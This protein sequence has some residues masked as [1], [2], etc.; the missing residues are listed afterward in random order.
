MVQ[1]HLCSLKRGEPSAW[2]GSSSIEEA[3]VANLGF[4]EARR[5][6]WGF[7]QN[8]CHVMTYNSRCEVLRGPESKQPTRKLSLWPQYCIM[9]LSKWVLGSN[10]RTF[11]RFSHSTGN[12]SQFIAL[13]SL[14]P[15]GN[16][17]RG[18][19]SM[20]QDLPLNQYSFFLV[21]M[22]VAFHQQGTGK[23]HLRNCSV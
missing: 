13:F 9:G 16:F 17:R 4:F 22:E 10:F 7:L 3:S 18:R 21:K 8:L 1:N 20:C 11:S 19:R 14:L 6:N 5:L 12:R 15:G 2:T 23:L